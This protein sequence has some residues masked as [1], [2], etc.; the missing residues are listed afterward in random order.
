[1]D[2]NTLKIEWIDARKDDVQSKIDALRQKLSLKGN[3]VSESG[4]QR[5]IEIF[6]APLTPQQ[7][8]EKICADVDEKGLPALLDYSAR[9]DR[10]QLSA[11][12]LRVPQHELDD[13]LTQVEPS[14]LEA[15]DRVRDN[16]ATFQ[17]A[18]LHK[19]IRIE[20][21]GGWLGQ[22]YLPLRRV[23]VCVPGGAAAYPSSVI[24]TV[25]PAQVAGVK[26]IA[27]MAPPRLA[28]I[29]SMVS[30]AVSAICGPPNC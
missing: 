7:V 2:Q 13:A 16:V 15:V 4:K 25:V 18:I 26:E 20:R 22:R 8:V 27:V 1:M 5:T 3:I 21:P 23:G 29:S 14:F 24:M 12:E 9:I 30:T 10:A 19:S 17:R 28:M 11:A 6:G